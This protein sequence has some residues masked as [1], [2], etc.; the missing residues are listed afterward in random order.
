LRT[1]W[2]VEQHFKLSAQCT[3]NHSAYL[4]SD[5]QSIGP[6]ISFSHAT[7]QINAQ[8]QVADHAALDSLPVVSAEEQDTL[9]ACSPLSAARSCAA[10]DAYGSIAGDY[11]DT[12]SKRRS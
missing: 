6:H 7:R 10:V 2:H 5:S 1:I 8:E 9:S 11:Y 4:D 3:S 12:S